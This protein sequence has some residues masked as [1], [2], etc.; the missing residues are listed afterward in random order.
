MTIVD[1]EFK[2]TLI[3]DNSGYEIVIEE[4]FWISQIVLQVHSG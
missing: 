3:N 2:F 1:T 4:F